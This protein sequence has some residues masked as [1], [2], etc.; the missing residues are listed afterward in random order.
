MS[1]SI[2]IKC[3]LVQEIDEGNNEFNFEKT[4]VM[5]FASKAL[6]DQFI[7]NAKES[8]QKIISQ[9]GENFDVLVTSAITKIDKIKQVADLKCTVRS[10]DQ[11]CSPY[12]NYTNY[13]E[14]KKNISDL[15][16]IVPNEMISLYE[17]TNIPY[18]ENIKKLQGIARSQG[19]SKKKIDQSQMT[20]R[21]KTELATKSIIIKMLRDLIKFINLFKTNC[22]L[23]QTITP[24]N[25]VRLKRDKDIDIASIKLAHDYVESLSNK[26]EVININDV[27]TNPWVNNGTQV[28]VD[29]MQNYT[30]V[31][32]IIRYNVNCIFNNPQTNGPDKSYINFLAFF[33]DDNFSKFKSTIRTASRLNGIFGSNVDP[34]F[35]SVKES[36]IAS[37]SRGGRKTKKQKYKIQDIN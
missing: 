34:N 32:A 23:V 1:A 6:Y 5:F 29:K 17:S 16:K 15:L 20:V 7:V 30:F 35:R 13:L 2:S 25:F 24:P 22:K 12:A 3:N 33:N 37:Y 8:Y 36:M 21:D 10:E 26:N 18:Q 9:R 4:E 19:D 31:M 28:N 14:I 27:I 11:K